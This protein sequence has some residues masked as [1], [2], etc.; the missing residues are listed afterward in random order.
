MKK[1]FLLTLLLFAFAVTAQVKIGNNPTTLGTSSLLELE[2]TNK[3]LV[4]PRVANTAAITAPVNGMIIYDLSSNCIKGYEN[5]I[6]SDCLSASATPASTIVAVCTG[7]TGTYCTPLLSG[8][9]Y[10]VTLTN[11]DFASKQVKPLTSDLTLSGI[12]GAT[13]TAVSPSVLT[14]INAGA[15]RVITYT[16]GGTL[17]GTGTLTGTFAKQ[18]LTCSSNVTVGGSRSVAAASSSPTICLGSALTAITHATTNAQG[19]GTASGLP[20][21]VTAAWASNT[22][23]ISGTP[24]VSGTFNYS[25]PINGCGAAVNA[26]GTITVLASPGNYTLPATAVT[27]TGSTITG[28]TANWTALSGATGYTVEYS[29]AA[30]GPW[31]AFPSNPYAGTSASITGL[32]AISY[33]FRITSIGGTCAGAQAIGVVGCGVL[34]APG[35]TKEFL[36]HNLGADT[37]LD[38]HVPVVGLQGAYIQ[39]GR[40]GPN[41]TGDSR[42]D[43]QTA[44][45]TANFAAAPTSGNA[46]AAAISGWSTS[47]ATN[48]SWGATKTANDPCPAGYRVPTS[49]EWTG[50]NANNTASRTGTFSENNTNYGVALHYG[51]NVSTKLLTLPAAGNRNNTDGTLDNRGTNGFYWS[52][53]ENGTNAFGLGF[54]SSAVSPAGSNS[55]TYGFSLRC[56]AE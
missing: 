1:L 25:I 52:S 31:T 18:G 6:W 54:N 9:T 40:R 5:G 30:T 20:A 3:G 17:A 11:N 55:R 2:S 32:S 48:G 50:V 38:P 14:T 10:V 46:N 16:I 41:T 29:T 56:I 26:T 19:I 27:R 42:V 39:W 53:T 22:I 8:T 23:T 49:A 7:F 24:S 21:G 34:V 35:V 15:S 51:P 36:C 45:N 12:T 44:G 47:A 43:W 28:F 37:S 13:V 33:H 4:L